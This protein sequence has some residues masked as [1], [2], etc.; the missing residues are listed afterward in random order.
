MSRFIHILIIC[1]TDY[2]YV[3]VANGQDT[4]ILY[5]NIINTGKFY[6]TIFKINFVE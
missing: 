5:L 1:Q 4:L 2:R 6:R 3:E